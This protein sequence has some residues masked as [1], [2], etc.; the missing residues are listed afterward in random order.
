MAFELGVHFPLIANPCYYACSSLF[1]G[2]TAA[3]GLRKYRDEFWGVTPVVWAIWTPAHYMT[4]AVVAPRF[5]IAW[6]A[7][8]SFGWL[9]VLSTL[10]PMTSP[11]RERRDAPDAG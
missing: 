10:N 8:V 11:S 7:S 5:R 1:T 2:G 3:D 9:V 4:F 6:V